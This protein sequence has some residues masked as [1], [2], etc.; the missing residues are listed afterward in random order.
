M[1]YMST[2]KFNLYMHGCNSLIRV[3][4]SSVSWLNTIH[5]LFGKGFRTD[6][7]GIYASESGSTS[8]RVYYNQILFTLTYSGSDLFLTCSGHD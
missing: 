1:A 2:L 7:L 3:V 5:A 8:A 4:L 6:I